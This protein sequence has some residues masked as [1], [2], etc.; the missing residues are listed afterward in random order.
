MNWTEP[1]P[2]TKDENHVKL[3]SPVG[4]FTIECKGWKEYDDYFITLNAYTFIGRTNTLDEAKEVVKQYL[5]N[6]KNE[7]ENFLNETT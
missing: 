1:K 6:L 7:L 2:P 5:T 3:I 4:V